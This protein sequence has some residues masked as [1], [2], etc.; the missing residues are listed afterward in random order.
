MKTTN[1]N[2]TGYSTVLEIE[3]QKPNSVGTIKDDNN[4]PQCKVAAFNY[5]CSF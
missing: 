2:I 4:P 3:P 5:C 1:Y